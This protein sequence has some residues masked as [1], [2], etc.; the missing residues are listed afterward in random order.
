MN[1]CVPFFFHP[2]DRAIYRILYEEVDEGDVDIHNIVSASSE[3]SSVDEYR[4]PKAG[5]FYNLSVR[6]FLLHTLKLD[7]PVSMIYHVLV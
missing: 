7:T 4:Y 2:G 1:I 5:E 6:T 3:G